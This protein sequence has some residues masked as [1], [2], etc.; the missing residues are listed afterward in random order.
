MRCLHVNMRI[1]FAALFLGWLSVTMPVA[2]VITPAAADGEADNNEPLFYPLPP[3]RPRLQFLAKFSSALDVSSR[4]QGFRNFVFGGEENEGHLVN[5]P[6]GLAIHDGAIYVVDTR[7]SGWGV[8]DLAN[9]RSRFVRP[10]GGGTLKKPINISID[11]DGTRYVTDTGREQVL[12]YD[13]ND[14]FIRAFGLDGQFKP[15]DVAIIEDRL[16]VTDVAHHQIHVLDKHSGE[17]LTT[18][19]EPGREPGQLFQP[20]NLAVG[21]DHTL[22]VSDTGNFRIQQFGLDGEFIREIG[23]IGTSPGQFARPKGIAVARDELIYVVDAAFANV[24]VLDSSGL[25]LMYFGKAGN[26]RDS[27]SLPTV[28]KIDYANVQYFQQYVAPDFE[29]EYLVAVAS[30][31]GKNKVVVFGFGSLRE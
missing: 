15:V 12:V 27:L 17:L 6:Y 3:N 25:A 13:S 8:F 14:R 18:I 22:Y 26:E 21:P 2:G 4:K 24:Q 7:G 20:T 11:T 23:N 9:K 19:S 29:L 16:Y 31:F 28:V 10:G 1:V 5:K 30:Q